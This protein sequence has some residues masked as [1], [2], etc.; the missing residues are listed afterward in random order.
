MRTVIHRVVYDNNRLTRFITTD[1]PDLIKY[2]SADYINHDNT[3]MDYSINDNMVIIKREIIVRN[4]RHKNVFTVSENN[5]LIVRAFATA[6]QY[7]D[8][9]EQGKTVH[10]SS[11]TL[12]RYLKLAYADP[13]IVN[14]AMNG[15][16]RCS[17][18]ELFKIAASNLL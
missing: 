1:N 11:A 15:E 12:Y 7:R 16:L 4:T 5:R 18:D 8:L 3:Y 13:R 2:A 10:A 14:Q 6:F 17:V 9:Y